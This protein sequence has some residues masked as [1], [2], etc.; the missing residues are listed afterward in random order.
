[1]GSNGPPNNGYNFKNQQPPVGHHKKNAM[2]LLDYQQLNSSFLDQNLAS[3]M[4]PTGGKQHYPQ[5]P[6][7]GRF[8][9]QQRPIAQSNFTPDLKQF[10]QT[11]QAFQQQ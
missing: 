3:I 4:G 1:M 10:G 7:P 11:N 6:Q 2:S 9:V 5:E 8:T